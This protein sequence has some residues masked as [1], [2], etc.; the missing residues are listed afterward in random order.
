MISACSFKIVGASKNL[1]QTAQLGRVDKESVGQGLTGRA[2]VTSVGCSSVQIQ[3]P[4]ISADI[5]GAM[6]SS[7][8]KNSAEKPWSRAG[9]WQ[10]PMPDPVD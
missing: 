9:Q 6:T 5:H 7:G 4:V 3:Q 2:Q 1:S 8:W 10:G